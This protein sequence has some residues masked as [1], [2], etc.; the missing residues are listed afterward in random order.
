MKKEFHQEKQE[1][2]HKL[3]QQRQLVDTLSLRLEQD[4]NSI[5]E[6]KSSL[7]QLRLSIQQV[8]EGLFMAP[9]SPPP[10]MGQTPLFAP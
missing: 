3:D 8:R 5:A 6:E 1:Q 7:Q 10:R 2:W 4:K 9:P